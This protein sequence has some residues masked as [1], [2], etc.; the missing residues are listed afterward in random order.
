MEQILNLPPAPARPSGYSCVDSDCDATIYYGEEA[1][2]LQVAILQHGDGTLLKYPVQDEEDPARDFLFEPHYFC[3]DCWSKTY[4]WI[5]EQLE[6]KPPVLD[7][8]STF[9]CDCCGSGIRECL[10][11]AGVAEV[12]E[13]QR[14]RRA[15]DNLSG[16]RFEVSARP[17]IVCMSCL[18]L[19]VE[20]YIELWSNLTQTGECIDCCTARCW[21]APCS[22][23]CHSSEPEPT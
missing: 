1:V 5:K 17:L 3:M 22:C 4:D 11:Y 16:P 9:A 23:T 19:V 20:G 6:D 2:L 14:S 8:L 15:P 13:F 10:E 12:G 18:H 7:P 21:R